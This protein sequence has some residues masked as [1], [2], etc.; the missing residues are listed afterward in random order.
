ME[1]KNRDPQKSITGAIILILIGV[2]FLVKRL[3]LI[4]IQNWW[5]LFILIPA[6]SSLSNLIQD[7]R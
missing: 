7:L 6:I 4:E 2:V 1:N 5:A 3:N